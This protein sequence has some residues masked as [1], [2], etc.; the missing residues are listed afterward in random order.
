M[1]LLLAF[2]GYIVFASLFTFLVFAVDKRRAIR[3]DWR[4]PERTLL[5]LS[6]WGGSP[7]A[8][9]AQALLRHKTRKQPFARR[10]NQVIAIQGVIGVLAFT[11]AGAHLH[12]AGT[13][14]VQRFQEELATALPEPSREKSLP[15]RFGPGS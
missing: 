8:K 7:G 9:A 2:L 3:G 15:R 12:D 11:P 5:W 1:T 13:T 4:I 14:V 6:F 10:L